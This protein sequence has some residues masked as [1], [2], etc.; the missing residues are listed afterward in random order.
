MKIEILGNGGAFDELSTSYLINDE[1]LVD[2]SDA[3]AHKYLPTGKLD[4]V[5]HVF[6]THR[7]GDHINGLETLIY[8]FSVKLLDFE[9]TGLTIYGGSDIL[10]YFK[11]LACSINPLNGEYNQPFEFV[12]IDKSYAPVVI[13]DVLVNSV[14]SIHMNGTLPGY[15]YIFYYS[16]RRRIIITGDMDD[17]NPLITKSMLDKGDLLLFHDM[18]WTGLPDVAKEHQY[19]PKEK[20]VYNFYGPQDNLI[21]IHT[22]KELKYYKKAKVGDIYYV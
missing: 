10:N 9:K 12:N 15:S 20:D 19:H 17:V 3:I 22:S 13:G 7:H 2:C 16:D 1:I 6:F 8:F 4:N 5:K 14:P 21:G 11:A 18:G